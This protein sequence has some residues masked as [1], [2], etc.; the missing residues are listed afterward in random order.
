MEEPTIPALLDVLMIEPRR[1]SFIPGT[2]ARTHKKEP[3]KLTPSVR[4][5][6]SAVV[7]PSILSGPASENEDITCVN[8]QKFAAFQSVFWIFRRLP[9]L[10]CHYD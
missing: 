10:T 7:L 4:S 1:A 3:R 9:T 5:Q 8:K 6:I 2:T